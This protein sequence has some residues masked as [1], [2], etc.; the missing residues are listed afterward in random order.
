[1]RCRV[2]ALVRSRAVYFRRSSELSIPSDLDR[3]RVRYSNGSA[4]GSRKGREKTNGLSQH[5]FEFSAL[6]RRR[7][8]RRF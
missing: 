8:V 4:F 5:T 7:G 2:G 6:A 1:M 3:V